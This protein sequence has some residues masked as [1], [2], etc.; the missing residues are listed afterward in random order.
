ML[1]LKWR[2]SFHDEIDAPALA[3][4]LTA[5]HRYRHGLAKRRGLPFSGAYYWIPVANDC[6]NLSVWPSAFHEGGEAG[7][8]EV[9]EDLVYI[10]AGTFRL[11]PTKLLSAIG[12]CPYGFPRGRVV[13]MGDGSWGVAHGNDHP[14]GYELESSVAEAFCLQGAKPKFFFDEHEQ[15]NVYDREQVWAALGIGLT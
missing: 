4:L 5:H 3:S 14:K 11:D 13:K 7:H 6:W 8:V 10:L 12:N 1:K 2:C 15:M 9:W